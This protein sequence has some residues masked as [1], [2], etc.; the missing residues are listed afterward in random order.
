M[1]RSDTELLEQ[2]K[3][4]LEDESIRDAPTERKASFLEQKGLQGA[5]I[6]KLLRNGHRL[7]DDNASSP[8]NT[9]VAS[10]TSADIRK[11][12]STPITPPRDVPPI[13]TYPEFLL[14][15]EKPPPLVTF[16]RLA[17]AAYGFASL[18]ALTYGA[19]KYLVQ[20]M[21]ESLTSARHELAD[22]A[23]QNLEKLN[24]KLE[25]MVSHVPY[26][27]SS[28]VLKRKAGGHHDEDDP[29]SIDSDPTELFHRDVT[30]QT[31]PFLSRHSSISS[32]LSP[33]HTRRDADPTST[34]STRLSTIHTSLTSLLS[35]T[36][37]SSISPSANESLK[38]TVED[39]QTYLDN[40]LFNDNFINPSNYDHIYP[41]FEV[42][43]A[44]TKK[45]KTKEDDEAEKFKAE[46][47]AVKGALLGS[48]TFPAGK[49]LVGNL[50]GAAMVGSR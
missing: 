23:L 12:A 28:A 40:L 27:S 46:I 35:S 29:A 26:T 48:R 25:S 24:S 37:H 50:S 4:W 15:P 36:T 1:R 22:I 7:Q 19:S 31:S 18:T 42:Q 20:P 39:L 45:S 43:K 3:R 16:Q 30:Q 44:A 11:K 34:Q 47:R 2:A 49:K 8:S 32:S 38:S 13:I 9:Q 33:N 41:N 21:L 6:Q 17:Y 10:P 5:D 14:R